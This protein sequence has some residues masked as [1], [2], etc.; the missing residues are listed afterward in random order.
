MIRTTLATIRRY[1]GDEL[2]HNR[3]LASAP[4][5]VHS[6]EAGPTFGTG[7]KFSRVRALHWLSLALAALGCTL[8]S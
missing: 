2:L 1:A 3:N 7:V 6:S 5:P 8:N 4:L